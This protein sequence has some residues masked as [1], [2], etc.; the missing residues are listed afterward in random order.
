MDQ[1]VRSIPDPEVLI[2]MQPEELGQHLLYSIKVSHAGKAH[3]SSFD[4]LLFSPGTSGYDRRFR[5]EVLD[6]I[7]EAWAWLTSEALLVPTSGD[8]NGWCRLSRRAVAMADEQDFQH[9]RT[10]RLLPREILHSRISEDVWLNFMRGKYDLAVFEAMRAVEINVRE[11]SGIED[12]GVKLMRR[13]FHPESG[14]LADM[15]VEPGERQARMD[16]FA[17][18]IG[19]YKNPVSHR[20]IPLSEPDEVIEQIILASHLLR[21][22]DSRKFS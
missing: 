1:L 13:A 11:A 22:I 3:P 20:H 21:I 6:A 4:G 16:L 14:P 19:T 12:L 17:G 18:A 15:S 10:A 8:S 9:Y 7:F 5:H 2:A